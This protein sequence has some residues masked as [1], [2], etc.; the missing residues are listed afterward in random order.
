[1]YIR[2][3]NFFL[4]III[5]AAGQPAAAQSKVSPQPE[6]SGVSDI[7]AVHRTEGDS[8]RMAGDLPAAA[9]AYRLAYAATA[10]NDLKLGE[11]G[12]SYVLATTLA[13]KGNEPD[14]AFTYLIES[15]SGMTSMKV[16]YDPDLH[17]LV[18]DERWKDVEDTMLYRLATTVTG[19]FDRELALRLLN[20][21]RNEWVGRYH[22]MLLFR[23]TGGQSPVLSMLSYSMGERHIANEANLIEVLKEKGWPRMSAVGED[24]AYAASN[25]LT[26]MGLE[27]RQTYLPMLAEACEAGEADWAE[28]APSLDRT[29]LE[30]GRLQVYGT[31]MQMDE[32]LGSY[33]TYDLL[34]PD[35][36]EDRRAAIGLEPLAVQLERFNVAMKRDFGEG[37]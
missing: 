33:V 18:R 34:D 15:M 12:I 16:L 26:H 6:A 28:Y 22:I 37:Q 10:N 7:V 19:T 24:A 2:L 17:F 29:E 4:L 27:A 25:V 30:S 35:S 31:Q 8:L 5:V 11:E 3:L 32:D 9:E 36:V 20:I 1:M 21:R 13:L 14:D 23:Q